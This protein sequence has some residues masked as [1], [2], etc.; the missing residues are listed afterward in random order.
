MSRIGILPIDLPSGVTVTVSETNLVTLK[1]PKGEISQQV[2]PEIKVE[3]KENQVTIE[4]P[5][6]EKRHKSLH[7]LYRSLVNNMVVGV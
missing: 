1:V 4:R 3:I 2:D 6:D 7:G 5:T